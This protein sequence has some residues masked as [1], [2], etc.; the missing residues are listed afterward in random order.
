MV[1]WHITTHFVVEG[2]KCLAFDPSKPARG[3]L[4]H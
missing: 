3:Q 2:R 4:V 1:I